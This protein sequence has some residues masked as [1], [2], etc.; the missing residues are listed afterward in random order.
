MTLRDV[1][2]TAEFRAYTDQQA[3]D[4]LLATVEISRNNSAFT[5]SGLNLAFLSVGIDPTILIGA[6]AKL[7]AIPIGGDDL[8][9]MLLS[10]GVDFTLDAIRTQILANIQTGALTADQLALCNAALQIGIRTGARWIKEGLSVEPSL[11]DITSARTT[12]AAEDVTEWVRVR[13]NEV[14]TAIDAGTVLTIDAA[15]TALGAV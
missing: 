1:L 15:R 10:G 4:A 6:R 7:K 13:C 8:E 5:Y 12:I 9:A 2:K 3:L 11:V 14:L